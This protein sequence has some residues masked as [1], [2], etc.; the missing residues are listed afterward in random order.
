MVEYVEIQGGLRAC[1]PRFKLEEV[2]LDRRGY[3]L[4]TRASRE[5]ARLDGLVELLMSRAHGVLTYPL[6][7]RE[8]AASSRIEGTQASFTDAL[9]H[10]AQG[11][12]FGLRAK[13]DVKE[14]INHVEASELG[15]RLLGEFPL[16]WGLLRLLHGKLLEGVRGSQKNPGEFR[17]GVVYIGGASIQNASY[18]P[19]PPQY[20]P[21]LTS[22]FEKYLHSD[23]AQD[24]LIK[25]GILH[26]Q[27][28]LIHPFW[29][30][31]GRIGRLLISLFLK[32]AGLLAA[33]VLVLSE[34]FERN[35]T[36]YYDSLQSV[37]RTC[38]WEQWLNF[39]LRSVA[40]Q[41][42]RRVRL[43]REQIALYDGF[44]NRIR[45]ARRTPGRGRRFA[46]DEDV[47]DAVFERVVVNA[48]VL[49]TAT[50]M[51]G[52]TAYNLLERFQDMGILNQ[53][54]GGGRSRRYVCQP[55]LKI[56]EG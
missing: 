46:Y 55:L 29:D 4:L 42:A 28:E 30:G 34:Y 41:A 26:A 23:D 45:E 40:E 6:V 33:P 9:V 17:N 56:L 52:P 31:N 38:E 37:S 27:F 44:K 8:A 1:V 18:I 10:G 19:P 22:E 48:D 32:H 12:L 3:E 13:T 49:R 50:G 5:L 2:Q 54:T 36:T 39:F 16:S 7:V 51:S 25:C 21:E 11:S 43:C 35:R 53:M 14:I 20:L 47:L 15:F 24:P